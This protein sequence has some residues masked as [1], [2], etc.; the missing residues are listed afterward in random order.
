MAKLQAYNILESIKIFC[1]DVLDTFKI[2]Y[3]YCTVIYYA[4]V[5]SFP[6]VV[7]IATCVV[8]QLSVNPL[9]T[10]RQV[11]FKLIYLILLYLPTQ[12]IHVHYDEP[13]CHRLL[14]YL[15]STIRSYHRIL[16]RLCSLSFM[17]SVSFKVFLC[18]VDLVGWKPLL[19]KN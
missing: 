7:N 14:I 13:F 16:H 4:W 2:I 6:V 17:V 3:F 18:F 19:L 9:L 12:A 15:Q 10:G 1:R 11:K 5:Y 8:V